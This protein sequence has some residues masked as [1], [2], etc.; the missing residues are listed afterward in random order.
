MG[1]LVREGPRGAGIAD[2]RVPVGY[3]TFRDDDRTHEDAEH[4]TREPRVAGE[5]LAQLEREPVHPLADRHLGQYAIHQV[6]GS[7]RHA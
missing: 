2:F 7:I 5:A 1:V 4:R 3:A 6:R